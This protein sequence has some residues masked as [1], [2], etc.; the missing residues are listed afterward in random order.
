MAQN[1]LSLRL[2]PWFC[3]CACVSLSCDTLAIDSRMVS[4]SDDDCRL[5]RMR[6]SVSLP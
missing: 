5:S 2:T 4:F 6:L 3:L 1:E